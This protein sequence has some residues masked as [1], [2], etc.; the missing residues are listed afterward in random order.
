MLYFQ[1]KITQ[2]TV[3]TDP[4]SKTVVQIKVARKL[5]FCLSTFY[6]W[7]M[8]VFKLFP[9]YFQGQKYI[10]FFLSC[11]IGKYL[12]KK[13]EGWLPESTRLSCCID[14]HLIPQSCIITVV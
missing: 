13:L 6:P 1:H 7:I 8:S 14:S 12:H 2:G 11:P 9:F 3:N 5:K 4:H 10:N